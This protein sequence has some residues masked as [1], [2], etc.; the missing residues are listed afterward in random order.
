MSDIGKTDVY[1]VGEGD[2]DVSAILV[3]VYAALSEKG[4]SPRAQL[5]GYLLS[6]DPTYIT[7]HRNARSLIR[8]LDRTRLLEALVDAYVEH[9]LKP[10]VDRS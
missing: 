2:E 9:R 3:E 7:S 10:A 8:R 6:G 5:V 1:N 4:Y